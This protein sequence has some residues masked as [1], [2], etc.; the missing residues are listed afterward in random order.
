MNAAFCHVA[1]SFI[2][3]VWHHVKLVL[4]DSEQ[5]RII[6]WL[7]WCCQCFLLFFLLFH[8]SLQLS[9]R[10]LHPCISV[11]P[12]DGTCSHHYAPQCVLLLLLFI[13][14]QWVYNLV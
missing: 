13:L 4:R 5:H 12:C 1:A 3:C 2:A 7:I 6:N 14:W 8:L 9:F 10:L 11:P